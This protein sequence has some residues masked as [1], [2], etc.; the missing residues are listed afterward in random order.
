MKVAV[1][2]PYHR[3]PLAT[4]TRCYDSVRRQSYPCSHLLI[5]D[6]HPCEEIE[7]W[8]GVEHLVLPRAHSDFG[9]TPRS[10]GSISAF[11]QGYDAVTYLD[12]DNW[13][14]EDHVESLVAMCT[15]HDLAVGFS[16]RQIV[17]ST[18]EHCPFLDEGEAEGRR[19]DTS[20]FFI[21]KKAAFLAPIWA[22]M[23]PQFA[24]VGDLF[25][26]RVVEARVQRF[27][28]TGRRTLFYESH[29]PQHFIAM[30]KAPPDDAHEIDHMRTDADYDP[31]V[32]LARLGFDPLAG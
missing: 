2:T 32:N 22:L 15:E 29:W 25:M 23:D 18:G 12:A 16:L 14:A 11:S 27:G 4:L 26:L 28:W 20:C 5:A 19:V 17:L 3:E 30:G 10:I 7:G 8:A 9:N 13:Y 31:A 1:V 21:T 24:S 6:G